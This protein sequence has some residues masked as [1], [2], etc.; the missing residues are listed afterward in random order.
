MSLIQ[1]I[2]SID[3]NNIYDFNQLFNGFR[4]GP[5][6]KKFANILLKLAIFQYLFIYIIIMLNS[7]K[8]I[9]SMYMGEGWYNLRQ[10]IL[11]MPKGLSFILSVR[12]LR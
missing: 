8:M 11:Q 12:R 7:L 9:L 3:S 2:K 10:I 4:S 6:I 1:K 5:E